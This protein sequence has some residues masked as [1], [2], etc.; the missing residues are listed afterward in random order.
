MFFLNFY[1]HYQEQGTC[2]ESWSTCKASSISEM[3]F[4][5]SQ[6]SP[7]ES[8]IVFNGDWQTSVSC[9]IPL[10]FWTAH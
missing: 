10:S 4:L 5:L 1:Y 2:K 6:M 7:E 9:L 8:D 3:A